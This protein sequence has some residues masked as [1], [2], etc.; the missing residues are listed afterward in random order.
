MNVDAGL[1][2]HR[3]HIQSPVRTQN[4]TTG[5]W[6]T[7]WTTIYAD[8]PCSIE[9]LSVKDYLQSKA[10]QSE[11]KVRIK[12]RWRSGLEPEMRIVGASGHYLNRIF[13]PA[14]WLEDPESGQSWVTAPCTEGPNDG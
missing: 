10:S 7:S 2:R 3:V 12:M 13:S 11:I 14:G 1:L 6:S 5:D 9:P 8:V 4:A